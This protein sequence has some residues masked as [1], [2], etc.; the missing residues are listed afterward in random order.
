MKHV[1][2]LELYAQPSIT[3]LHETANLNFFSIFFI[4]LQNNCN[5]AELRDLFET[6]PK[7]VSHV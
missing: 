1:I 2:P 7:S 4:Y 5:I 3:H 6:F